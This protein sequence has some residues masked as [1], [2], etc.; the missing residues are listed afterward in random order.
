MNHN[1]IELDRR[2]LTLMLIAAGGLLGSMT[3]VA[4]TA[5]DFPTKSIRIIVMFP[6]GGGADSL[7]RLIGEQLSRQ[8]G[9]PVVVDNQSGGAGVIAVRELLNA[10]P[11]GHTILHTNTTIA[12]LTP[13]LVANVPYSIDDMVPVAGLVETRYL[14]LAREDFPADTFEELITLAKKDPGQLAVGDWGPT[15]MTRVVSTLLNMRTDTKFSYIPYRGEAPLTTD[16]LGG[17]VPLGWVTLP[18]ATEHVKSGKL[19]A[20]GLAAPKRSDLVPDVPTFIEL[21]LDEFVVSGWSGYFVREG[22][23]APIVE[24]LHA[25]VEKALQAPDVAARLENLGLTPLHMSTDEFSEFVTQENARLDAPL[26]V[27]AKETE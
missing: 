6:A 21:G 25:E 19:K 11:D 17:Q 14:L 9:V 15:S 8:M 13:K 22:T 5:E 27:M 24:L 1:R 16:L 3:R 7:N 12:A 23:P 4:W 26:E 10:E 20:F 2:K 18:S